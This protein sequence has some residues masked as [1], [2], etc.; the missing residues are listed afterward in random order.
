MTKKMQK[1]TVIVNGE[2]KQFNV[3]VV[4]RVDVAGSSETTEETETTQRKKKTAKPPA[5]DKRI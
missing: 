1:Q 4:E 3:R 2:E 5:T